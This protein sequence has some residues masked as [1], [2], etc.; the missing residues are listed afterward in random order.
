LHGGSQKPEIRGSYRKL[1]EYKEIEWLDSRPGKSFCSKNGMKRP[2][3][4]SY[5]KAAH[6][7]S[8]IQWKGGA[9]LEG[10]T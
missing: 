9:L 1:D 5:R 8:K 7:I 10:M 2:E 4:G 3:E 6:N